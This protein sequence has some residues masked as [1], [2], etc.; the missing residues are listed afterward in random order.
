VFCSVWSEL[1]SIDSK[2]I[3]IWGLIVDCFEVFGM[4]SVSVLELFVV[5]L[6]VV[7]CLA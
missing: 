2:L 6:S 3:D 5:L 1:D 7:M 4:K